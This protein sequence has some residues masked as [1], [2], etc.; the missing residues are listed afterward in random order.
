M[1]LPPNSA[2][3]LQGYSAVTNKPKVAMIVRMTEETLDALA[4]LTNT[5]RMD[6]EFGD[7]PV[8]IIFTSAVFLMLFNGYM[9]SLGYSYT[10]QVVSYAVQQRKGQSGALHTYNGSPAKQPSP[11]TQRNRGWQIL[12]RAGSQRTYSATAA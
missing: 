1:P 5:D 12:R 9:G 3:T 11:Q 10:G 8:S 6:V 2:I 7:K 4:N